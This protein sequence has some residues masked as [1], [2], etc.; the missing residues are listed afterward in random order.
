MSTT[1]YV[2]GDE[3]DVFADRSC[4]LT[5]SQLL[6]LLAAEQIAWHAMELEQGLGL[7][8]RECDVLRQ[9]LFGAG[10]PARVI[11]N[12]KLE[13][14]P[15]A[16]THKREPGRVLIGPAVR[17]E[18][19]TFE[20]AFVLDIAT[21]DRLCDHVTGRH[22]AGMLL[23]EA[24]RQATA[25]SLEELYNQD[26]NRAASWESMQVAFQS[27]VF[28]LPVVLRVRCEALALDAGGRLPLVIT[29]N[30]LQL[31]QSVGEFVFHMTAAPKRLLQR[32]EAMAANR[33][34]IQATSRASAGEVSVC[35]AE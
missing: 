19:Q 35:A 28:P 17:V 25:V 26:G 18:P 2:V 15:A 23:I 3:F 14:A 20:F 10:A 7:G 32:V 33:A 31:G 4:I 22:V 1:T 12:F 21:H 29:V 34:I 8:S 9:A 13:R 5:Y 6:A 27:F 16:M 30:A 24:A 11:E